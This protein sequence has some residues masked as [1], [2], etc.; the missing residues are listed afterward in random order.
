M[1]WKRRDAVMTAGARR[2]QR[3]YLVLLL[4]HT[5]AASF[6]W[7]LNTLFLLDA[8][9]TNTQASAADAFFTAGLVLFEVPTGVVADS[10]SDGAVPHDGHRRTRLR[11]HRLRSVPGIGKVLALT[12][13]YEI[14]DLARFDRVQELAWYARLVK[15]AHTAAGKVSGTGGAKIGNV[16]WKWAFSDAAVL[17]LRHAP[18]AKTLLGAIEKTHGTGKALSILAHKIGRAVYYMLS[19]GTVFSLERFRAVA[20]KRAGEPHV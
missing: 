19:R 2:V 17:F 4:L 13:L 12:I 15:W 8:G 6:I 14:H 18:G 3:V 16:H 9:L 1:R 20:A 5:L 10:Q 11:V 7:G